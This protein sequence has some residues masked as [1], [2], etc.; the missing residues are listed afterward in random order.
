MKRFE[1]DITHHPGEAF[2]QA[3][4]FC[5]ETGECTLDQVPSDE[6]KL[7]TG[8]LNEQ[9]RAGNLSKSP[10][11]KTELWPFGNAKLKKWRNSHGRK[12]RMGN[13]HGCGPGPGL[14]REQACV[15]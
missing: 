1:Y 5:T 14:R 8:I 12:H 2:K 7:L 6:T 13:G 11:A 10:L 4:Y 3:V 9:G 15:A